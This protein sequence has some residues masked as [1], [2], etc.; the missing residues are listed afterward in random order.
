MGALRKSTNQSS[1]PVLSSRFPTKLPSETSQNSHSVIKW[2]SQIIQRNE[3]S[4]LS[5]PSCFQP[6]LFCFICLNVLLCFFPFAS[7]QFRCSGTALEGSYQIDDR[8]RIINIVSEDQLWTPELDWGW[9][10]LSVGTG[11]IYP[12]PR[13]NKPIGRTFWFPNRGFLNQGTPQIHF[14]YRIFINNPLGTRWYPHLWKPPNADFV[15]PQM[16]ILSA[17]ST[18]LLWGYEGSYRLQQ[19]F[20]LYQHWSGERLRVSNGMSLGA[21]SL[22]SGRSWVA[23]N[24]IGLMGESWKIIVSG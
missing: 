5:Y 15:S 1:G 17:V 23:G 12:I 3:Q 20:P 9:P 21:A 22:V 8:L 19:P 11:G 13:S 24:N 4:G 6:I 10:L 14:N 7:T 18:P 16:L 2:N